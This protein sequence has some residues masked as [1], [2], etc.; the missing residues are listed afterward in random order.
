MPELILHFVTEQGTDT[1]AMAA[2]LQQKLQGIDG[3]TDANAEATE[4]RTMGGAVEIIAAISFVTTVVQS[5]STLLRAVEDLVNAWHELSARFP[6]LNKP[7][8]EI[9]RRKVPIDEL[10]EQ[11]AREVLEEQG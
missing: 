1:D 5:T 9:G 8:V 10:T 3:V 4:L 6:R 7:R 11:D 2:E